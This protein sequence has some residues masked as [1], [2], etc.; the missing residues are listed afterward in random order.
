MTMH[1]V[2]VKES[3]GLVTRMQFGCVEPAQAAFGLI[4]DLMAKG[5]DQFTEVIRSVVDGPIVRSEEETKRAINLT[6]LLF[7][8]PGG[9]T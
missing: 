3:T 8:Q 7:V 9:S 2:T 1:I 6:E 5:S 4:E